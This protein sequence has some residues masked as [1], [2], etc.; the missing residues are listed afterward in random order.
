MT[1]PPADTIAPTRATLTI[2]YVETRGFTRMSE[3][4]EPDVVLAR[5]AE[6]FTLVSAA[7]G[8]HDGMVRNVLNDNLVATFA[9]AANAQHAVETAQEIQREFT[10]LEEAWQ[11]RLRLPHRGG[12]GTALGRR[13]GR[14]IERR[15]KRAGCS[16]S[17]TG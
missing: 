12:D 17:A 2:L 4:L 8:R 5:I 9:G 3:I 16:S 14:R 15:V 11:Q 13:G 10:A 6:F 1:P 7:V